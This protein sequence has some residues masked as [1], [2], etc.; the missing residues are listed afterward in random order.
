MLLC[1]PQGLVNRLQ[2]VRKLNNFSSA[3]VSHVTTHT[4]SNPDTCLH[5]PC[6]QASSFPLESEASP[7]S[8]P[9]LQPG[10][11]VHP[12]LPI[13]SF[14]RKP[15]LCPPPCLSLTLCPQLPLSLL[16]LTD[17]SPHPPGSGIQS[18]GQ[19]HQGSASQS[20]TQR[21]PLQI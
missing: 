18:T 13:S 9:L 7:C 3:F 20:Q 2:V 19:G 16:N 4:A 1:S 8:Y 14:S 11:P 17:P 10:P 12:S 15:S 21:L 6:P 5:L